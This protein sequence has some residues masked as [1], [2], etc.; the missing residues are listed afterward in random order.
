M[1]QAEKADEATEVRTQDEPP[2]SG[3]DVTVLVETPAQDEVEAE[4]QAETTPSV[5]VEE[6]EQE[7]THSPDIVDVDAQ[8]I[9]QAQDQ[10]DGLSLYIKS[11]LVD[12]VECHVALRDLEFAADNLFTSETAYQDLGII[13]TGDL[14]AQMWLED[15]TLDISDEERLS[16]AKILIGH[17]VNDIQR[18]E[19]ACGQQDVSEEVEQPAPT[20]SQSSSGDDSSDTALDD[21]VDLEA[22]GSTDDDS[23][24]MIDEGIAAQLAEIVQSR[25]NLEVALYLLIHSGCFVGNEEATDV[26]NTVVPI[27]SDQDIGTFEAPGPVGEIEGLIVKSGEAMV[28]GDLTAAQEFADAATALLGSTRQQIESVSS[29]PSCMGMP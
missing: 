27:I 9:R 6:S 11:L 20:V 25:F 15:E 28:D 22:D 14:S 23:T 8:T 5:E 3:A 24:V 21:P 12:L 19:Y 18:A 1:E 7:S 4:A 16:Q 2:S 10:L 29:L 13:V 26:I 17:A